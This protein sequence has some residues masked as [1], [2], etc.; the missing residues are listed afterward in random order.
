MHR[1]VSKVSIQELMETSNVKFGTSGARGLVTEMTDKVC[2]AYTLG[3]IQ[4]LESTGELCGGRSDVAVAGDLRPSTDRIMQAVFAAISEK[5]YTPVNCG[6]IPSPAVAYYGLKNK[7]PAIMVTGSHIPDD[8]NG[9]KFN[10]ISGEILKSDE[11]RIRSQIVSLPEMKFATRGHFNSEYLPL[12]PPVNM[13]AETQYL[14]RYLDFFP[15]DFLRGMQIGFYQHSAV[16]RSMLPALLEQLGA[17][18]T[19]F[20]YSEDFV[21]VDTE[22][23]RPEDVQLAAD[24]AHGHQFDALYS[25][26]GD[27]DR[28]LVA[29]ENGKWL[30]GDIAGIL[31][32]EFLGADSVTTP[33]SCN[34]ALEKCGKFKDIRRTKIGSPYVVESMIEASDEG[35]ET[36]TGYE[37]NGGFLTNSCIKNKH[38]VLDPLPTRDTAIV[39]LAIL[40]LA[41]RRGKPVS[42]LVTDLPS[43]YTASGRL[44]AFPAERSQEILQQFNTGRP[45]IDKTQIE[46]AFGKVCGKVIDINRIDGVRIS[47]ENSEIIHLRPSGNAPEFRCYTETA[48]ENRAIA[49]NEQCLEIMDKWR[50]NG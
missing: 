32:C 26:D 20:G 34:T 9:I 27:G 40:G 14:K 2:F 31:A 49:L 43:R 37:A 23:I 18:V 35:Y 29:D 47:F 45:D 39:L 46:K 21:P 10:K 12:A 17:D 11:Q 22:A 28:P 24:M 42:Q 33:V 13:D 1:S 36:V 8:R 4:Y 7:I 30:R 3:F 5:G 6:K 15:P 19:R 44:K 50:L 38:G 16:G 25:T 41:L 48:S